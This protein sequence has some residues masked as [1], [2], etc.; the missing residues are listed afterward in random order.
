[1]RVTVEGHPGEAGRKLEDLA[2]RVRARIS[3]FVYA[4]GD[5]ETMEGVVGA[6]L[7]EK[8][9][10]LAVAESCTGG[11]VGH[12]LTN[13]PGSSSYL[14]GDF[15]TYSNQ[16]KADLLGVSEATLASHGAV[17]E[18]CVLEMSA[19]ARRRLGA[20]IA[21]ATSGI[22]G[23]DGGTPDKPVGTVCIALDANGMAVARRYQLR[24]TRDWIKLWASQ[25]ALD[26]VRRHLLGL[27]IAGSD[28]LRR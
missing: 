2:S 23:P 26:W 24:G 22:A 4:E 21:V 11:L 10:T 17:S 16:A 15:V 18:K 1:L 3:D 7:T 9:L 25:I 6:L 12:R 13:V 28:F 14:L 27:Q 5:D 20:D 19:G 8:K